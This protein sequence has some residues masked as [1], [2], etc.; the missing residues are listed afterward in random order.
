MESVIMESLAPPQRM[1]KNHKCL[2]D[3]VERS[4][5][6]GFIT[7][8]NVSSELGGGSLWSQTAN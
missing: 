6:G 2:D 3:R 5:M 1:A 8:A 7:A 4:N